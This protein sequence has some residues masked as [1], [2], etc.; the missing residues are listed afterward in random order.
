[1]DE[2]IHYGDLT[3][4]KRPTDIDSI[5]DAP[6]AGRR[7]SPRRRRLER[8]A[9]T[10]GVASATGRAR[11]PVRGG[12]RWPHRSFAEPARPLAISVA[13]QATAADAAAQRHARSTVRPSHSTRRRRPSRLLSYSYLRSY[14]KHAQNIAR[15]H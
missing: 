8:D 11:R 6:R 5:G 15:F 3:N 4:E 2:T 9:G 7:R 14:C 13:L 10:A 12:V 1:M